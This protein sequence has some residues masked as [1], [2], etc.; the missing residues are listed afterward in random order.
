MDGPLLQRA[1]TVELSPGNQ[2]IR[3]DV[4]VTPELPAYWSGTVDYT[5]MPVASITNFLPHFLPVFYEWNNDEPIHA[6]ITGCPKHMK[7]RATIR[8]PALAEEDCSLIELS[9]KD[10]ST[11]PS[12]ELTELISQGCIS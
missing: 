9:R 10:F 4:N 3:L 12:D 1:S 6:S 8:A 5:F 2:P 11:P 7:C